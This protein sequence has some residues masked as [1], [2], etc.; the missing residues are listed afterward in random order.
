MGVRRGS[1]G[2]GGGGAALASTTHEPLG[3]AAVGVGTTAA[4]ADHVH[5]LPAAVDTSLQ[6]A[7]DTGWTAGGAGTASIASGVAT[8]SM[9]STQDGVQLHRAAAMS[10]HSPALEV[11]ARITRTVSSSDF[12]WIGIALAS[13]AWDR[14]YTLLCQSDSQ[15]TA[16]HNLSGSWVTGSA[17]AYPGSATLTS[18]TLW[19][20]IVI[21]PTYVAWYLGEGATRPTSWTLVTT[22]AADVALLAAGSVVRLHAVG[23]R[24]TG[25]GT[26]TAE[27]ADIQWR[28]LLGAPT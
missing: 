18:G 3:V 12:H 14:G 16:G 1:R 28:S 25:T 2:G 11:T 17:T 7:P 21:T 5:A 8:L 15:A 6:A 19:A 24:A 9:S 23:G 13:A 26:V 22:R 20:R 10:P 27:V 4:R